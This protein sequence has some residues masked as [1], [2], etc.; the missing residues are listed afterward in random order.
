MAVGCG[1]C[2][3]FRDQL[4]K[5][6]S[7]TAT[8]LARLKRTDALAKLAHLCLSSADALLAALRFC[9]DPGIGCFRINSQILPLKTHPQQGYDM[10]T[11]SVQSAGMIL[12][13]LRGNLG[14]CSNG[15]AKSRAE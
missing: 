15:T 5:F 12:V 6:G 8:A 10:A 1:F 3:I 14:T 2:C 9:A 13:L 4:I 11:T 7:T